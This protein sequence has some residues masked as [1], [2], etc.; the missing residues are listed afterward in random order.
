M[1]TLSQGKPSLN[2]HVLA[3]LEKC[4][5]I[6]HLKQLQAFLITL[7][8]GQTQFF[9]FKLVRFCTLALANLEYA[10]FIFDHLN[11]PNVYL[12]T[13]MVTAYESLSDHRSSLLLFRDMVR[14]GRPRPNHFIY[15]HLLRS[16]PKFLE[17]RGT[18]LVHTQI[19]KSGFERYP[20]VQTALLDS[21]ARFCSDPETARRLFDE[22]SERNVV[23]WTAMISGYARLG[24]M[25]NAVL[26]FDD[27]PERHIP[28]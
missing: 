4:N 15:P 9:A 11:S 22:M 25:G 8:H 16:C 28:S 20:V 14:R 12:Y 6:N 24:K 27:M 17:S 18:E 2:Q 23:S 19:L 10:R 13:A 21:Y 5:H 1:L 7:G 26:L 3:V